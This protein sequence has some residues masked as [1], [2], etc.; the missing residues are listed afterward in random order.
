ME[1]T[2]YANWVSTKVVGAGVILTLALLIG[3]RY[4]FAVSRLAAGIMLILFVPAMVYTFCMLRA[5]TAL[6]YEGGGVQGKVL[7]IAL[8]HLNKAGWKGSGKLLDIGCGSGAMEVKAA[9]RYPKALITGVDAWGSTWD[10]SQAQCEHNAALEGVMARV[11]FRKADAAK[12]PFL[13][14]TFD[15]AVSNFVFHEVRSQRDK[16]ALIREALR[17]VKPGGAF[18]FQDVFYHK[19]YYGDIDQFVDA[20]R[21]YVKEIHFVDTRKPEGV[22]KFLNTP[23]VLGEMGLIYG[24][25]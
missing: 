2:H 14:D 10:Y 1:R 19:A 24:R 23:L 18:A 12:L 25:K 7:D 11:T 20:L 4:M 13:D 21:P 9:K 5:R 22:P 8:D 3:A 17:V 6:S 15:A 16:Q